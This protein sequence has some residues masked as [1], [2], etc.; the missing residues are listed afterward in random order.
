MKEEFYSPR[1]LNDKLMSKFCSVHPLSLGH[2]L[3]IEVDQKMFD[4]SGLFTPPT[5]NCVQNIIKSFSRADE[6]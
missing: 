2:R 5:I 4:I 3:D 1:V 6:S